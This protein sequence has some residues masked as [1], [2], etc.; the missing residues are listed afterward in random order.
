MFLLLFVCVCNSCV[1]HD[2]KAHVPESDIQQSRSTLLQ[3]CC[4][5]NLPVWHREFPN[6]WMR[7]ATKLLDRNRLYSSSVSHSVAEL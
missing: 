3:L 4:S 2:G 6:L 5:T 7:R 1:F